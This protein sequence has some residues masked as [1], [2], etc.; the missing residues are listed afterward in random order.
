MHRDLLIRDVDGV[1]E[2]QGYCVATVITD[3]KYRNHGLA[4][5]LLENVSRWMDGSGG[6]E[7][8]TLYSDVGMV[9]NPI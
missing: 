7:A 3:S 9:R 5:F 4:T 8:S 6:A 1:R 2:E